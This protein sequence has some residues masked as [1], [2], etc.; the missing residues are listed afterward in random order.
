MNDFQDIRSTIRHLNGKSLTYE[1]AN[2]I[3]IKAVSEKMN[4]GD[5]EYPLFFD[6]I[7]EMA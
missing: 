2:M 4:I 5:G 3:K 1:Q 6:N 7:A